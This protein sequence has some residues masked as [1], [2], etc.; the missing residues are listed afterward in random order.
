MNSGFAKEYTPNAENVEIYTSM[1]EKYI[2][3]GQFTEK[4]LFNH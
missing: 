4:E 2:K 1:Y 3:V